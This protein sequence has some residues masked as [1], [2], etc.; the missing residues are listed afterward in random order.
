MWLTVGIT[1]GLECV[2][3]IDPMF[4]I[5]CNEVAKRRNDWWRGSSVLHHTGHTCTDGSS[6]LLADSRV[7]YSVYKLYTA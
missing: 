4:W 6:G 3:L 1:Q 5:E 7:V 2:W